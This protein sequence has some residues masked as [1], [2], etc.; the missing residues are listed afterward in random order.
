MSK[1]LEATIEIT[2]SPE[3]VWRVVSDL[4]RMGEW[5]PQCRRMIVR[6][7]PVSAGTTTI[8]IN[9]KGLLVWPT[10]SNPAVA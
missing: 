2:A 6:G 4:K 1:T 10:T 3:Q 9:K 8:N 5:S 7:G